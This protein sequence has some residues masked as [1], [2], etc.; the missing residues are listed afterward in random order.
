MEDSIWDRKIDGVWLVKLS[1]SFTLKV[2]ISSPTRI[3]TVAAFALGRAD[4]NRLVEPDVDFV[5]AST[6]NGVLQLN[7][8]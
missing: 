3:S 7:P 2:V 5:V 8:A 6:E 1:D 4:R